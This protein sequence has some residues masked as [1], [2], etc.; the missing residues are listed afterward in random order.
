MFSATL[1]HVG[2]S[3]EAP[4]PAIF[5]CGTIAAMQS[6]RVLQWTK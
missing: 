4:S 3:V 1:Y 6:A 5:D 2:Q